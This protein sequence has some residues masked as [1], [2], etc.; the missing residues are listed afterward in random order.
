M[1]E[2]SPVLEEITPDTLSVD[3]LDADTLK[4]GS[5]EDTTAL[6]DSL[7]EDSTLADTHKGKRIK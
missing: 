2:L 3:T 1:V 4:A 6:V 5:F 7:P